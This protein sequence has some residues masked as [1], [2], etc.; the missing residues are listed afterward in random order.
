[1][2]PRALAVLALVTANALW[3]ASLVAIKVAGVDVPPL[4]LAFLRFAIASMFLL[5]LAVRSGNHL[6]LDRQTALLGMTGVALLVICLNFGLHYTSA[7]NATLVLNGGVP[8]MGAFLAMRMLRERPT[9][10]VWFGI[11]ASVVGVAAVLG[12]GLA[13]QSS[14]LGDG[15]VLVGAAGFALYTVLGQRV[16]ADSDLIGVVA[17][18]TLWGTLFLLPAAVTELATRGMAAPTLTTVIL[19]VYLGAGCSAVTYLLWAYALRHLDASQV[20][21]SSTLEP[22]VGVATAALV[23]AEPFGL[24]QVGG[25]ALILSGVWLTSVPGP[26][27]RQATRRCEET[28][29]EAE[30][31]A[32]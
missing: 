31:G 26:M 17:G 22:L 25:A 8:V 30:H 3:G 13:T 5:P 4:T 7:G 24:P 18:S 2:S 11:V 21:A 6:R 19:L 12:P 16:F 20:A 9:P 1:L 10:R 15:L 27:K 14:L 23:L 28:G 32:S 29:S